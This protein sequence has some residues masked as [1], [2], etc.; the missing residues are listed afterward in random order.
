MQALQEEI[1]EVGYRK[2]PIM[3]GEVFFTLI[4][5]HIMFK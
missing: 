5:C 2:K 4:F 3:E 1:T